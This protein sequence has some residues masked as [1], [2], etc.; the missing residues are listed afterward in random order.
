MFHRRNT[1][2]RNIQ[3]SILIEVGRSYFCLTKMKN[4]K[5]KKKISNIQKKICLKKNKQPLFT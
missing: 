2:Y 5:H 3:I 1:N 4:E